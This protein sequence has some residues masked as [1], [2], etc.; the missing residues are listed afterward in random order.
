MRPSARATLH[1]RGSHTNTFETRTVAGVSRAENQGWGSHLPGLTLLMQGLAGMW[2]EHRRRPF[3]EH[4]RATRN[5]G[6][7]A[8]NC[9]PRNTGSFKI[10]E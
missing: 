2:A 1:S 9:L 10:D 6:A 3:R 7:D 8:R 4:A 5:S